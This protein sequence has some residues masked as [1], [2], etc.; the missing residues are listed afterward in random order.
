MK[1]VKTNR[2][3]GFSAGRPATTPH[4]SLAPEEDTDRFFLSSHSLFAASFSARHPQNQ[5]MRLCSWA[6]EWR[7]LQLLAVS[8]I[9]LPP[10]GCW[11]GHNGHWTEA[12]GFLRQEGRPGKVIFTC[13]QLFGK[14]AGDTTWSI[15]KDG[16]CFSGLLGPSQD[17]PHP[18]HLRLG[19]GQIQR[20][21]GAGVSGCHQTATNEK[22]NGFVG[23]IHLTFDSWPAQAC[24]V[25]RVTL[26]FRMP[27]SFI[28]DFG[29]NHVNHL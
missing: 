13:W 19:L 20:W 26:V 1:N 14:F 3:S 7:P 10:G 9:T 22:M 17:T 25:V 4:S 24:F 5:A 6:T 29:I 15:N 12:S 21:V 2:V 18:K 23:L 8:T 11:E 27:Y 28:A 16:C